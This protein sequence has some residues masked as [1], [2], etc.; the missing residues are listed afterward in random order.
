MQKQVFE[1]VSE[2]V[3]P[4]LTEHGYELI[5]VEYVKE[6]SN[7]YL[8]VYV[9][10]EAGIDVEDCGLISDYLSAKLDENDPIP[11]AYFLEVSSPG[12]ERPLKKTEDFLKAINKHVLIT[13][14]EPFEKLQ[15]FEG[16]L[17][18]FDDQFA[19]VKIK[20]REYAI[21]R[22]LVAGARLAILF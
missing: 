16:T 1:V 14:S 7:W 12:A 3:Q 2:L 6:A 5:D 21:P 18:Q 13:T 10:K 4:F 19:V 22:Q 20:K 17:I 9:D 11:N 15:E 8:R